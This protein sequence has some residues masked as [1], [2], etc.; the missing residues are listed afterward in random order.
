MEYGGASLAVIDV[1]LTLNCRL[2]PES[3]LRGELGGGLDTSC[4]GE[5][6]RY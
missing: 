2:E 6:N 4:N 3:R 1:R 5:L